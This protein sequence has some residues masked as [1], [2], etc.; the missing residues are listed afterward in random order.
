MNKITAISTLM[1]ANGSPCVICKMSPTELM[2]AN[3]NAITTIPLALV[4][5]SHAMRKP[6]KP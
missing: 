6:T 4:P 5:A 1:T 3:R 2:K